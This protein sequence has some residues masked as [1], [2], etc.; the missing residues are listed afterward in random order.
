[1]SVAPVAARV[2]APTRAARAAGECAGG[3]VFTWG[4]ATASTPRCT[5][6]AAR[7]PVASDAAEPGLATAYVRAQ[8]CE[9]ARIGAADENLTAVSAVATRRAVSAAPAVAG[10]ASVATIFAIRTEAASGGAA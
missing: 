1:L 3:T 9:E 2:A 7:P 8:E 6:R 5:A 4:G 10:T